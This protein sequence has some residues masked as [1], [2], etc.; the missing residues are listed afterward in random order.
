MG[1]EYGA[2]KGKGLCCLWIVLGGISLGGSVHLVSVVSLA[3]NSSLSWT[4]RF[5]YRAR[6]E[7]EKRDIESKKR[8]CA[9]N[10]FKGG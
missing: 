3:I 2:I 7:K 8:G 10:F 5:L 1:R 9:Q 4:V 6:K